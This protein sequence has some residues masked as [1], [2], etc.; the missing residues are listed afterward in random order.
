MYTEKPLKSYS[1]YNANHNRY[2]F[3]YKY[4][5]VTIMNTKRLKFC[6]QV[7]SIFIKI[8]QLRSIIQYITV[9]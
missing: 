1:G 3:L 9:T 2:S 4:Q 6:T 7:F 8:F 5:R